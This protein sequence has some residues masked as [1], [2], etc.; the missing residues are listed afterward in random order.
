MN[1]DRTPHESA[2]AFELENR[3]LFKNYRAMLICD[4]NS[5]Y[6]GVLENFYFIGKCTSNSTWLI[7]KLLFTCSSP[8]S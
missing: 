6:E 2:I 1:S 3:R 5:T 4:A 7:S 8:L